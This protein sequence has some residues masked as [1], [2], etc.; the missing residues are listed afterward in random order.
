VHLQI[1]Q[2]DLADAEALVRIH[3][4]SVHSI[5]REFYPA[6]RLAS[7][8]PPPDEARFEW[9]RNAVRAKDRQLL[10]AKVSEALCGFAIATP[11][12]GTIHALYV[13]PSH[14]RQGVGRSLL[15]ATER[16]L[17]SAGADEATLC[18]SHNAREFYATA[19]YRFIAPATQQL[20]D[21]TELECSQMSKALAGTG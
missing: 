4:R 6:D 1:Q 9:M 14:A 19:G 15:H 8:S 16:E 7:W 3:F 13:D 20:S 17:L 2:A 18:A 10:V 12:S 21:G 11:A 5:S